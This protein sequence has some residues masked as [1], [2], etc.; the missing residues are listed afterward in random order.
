[1]K[2]IGL[3]VTVCLF[4]LSLISCERVPA[5][6]RGVL[7]TDY[8]KNGKSDYVSVKGRVNTFAPGTELYVIPT[9][10]QRA[11]FEGIMHIKSSDN[12]DFT[13]QPK[14]TYYVIESMDV[15]VVFE[16]SR[17]DSA[18]NFLKAIEDNIIEPLMY[19]I[20]K[21]KS[22]EIPGNVLMGEG[23]SLRFEKS[24]ETIIKEKLAKKGYFIENFTLN[25]D[26]DDKVKKKIN[27][28]NESNSNLVL[29]DKQIVEQKKQNELE[30]LKTEQ[31]IIR[32]R[33]LTPQILQEQFIEAWKE[34]KQPLYGNT[35]INKIV[36]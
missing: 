25:L 11:N 13:T 7:M 34:T 16:N 12:V 30:M 33:G 24:V 2:K 29:L 17:L 1:M 32:S 36:Q 27:A 19:D 31:N 10:S 20:I 9:W 28:G 3:I 6:H 26:Y 5:N 14:Y 8:G 18:S 22:R 35:P 15:D 4:A 23:E 21:D